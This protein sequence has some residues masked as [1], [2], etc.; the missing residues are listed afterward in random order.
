MNMIDF[1]AFQ[2]QIQ[3]LSHAKYIMKIFFVAFQ[4][5]PVVTKLSGSY[6]TRLCLKRC[7]LYLSIQMIDRGWFIR[8]IY[9]KFLLMMANQFMSEI[10]EQADNICQ[11]T[12]QFTFITIGKYLG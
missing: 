4:V 8:P 10:E 6:L 12:L 9:L 3:M 5:S 2:K 1:G 11:L 7:V